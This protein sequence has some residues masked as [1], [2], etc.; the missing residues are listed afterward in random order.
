MGTEDTVVGEFFSAEV[1]SFYI[2][3]LGVA[4]T[5]GWKTETEDWV[6]MGLEMIGHIIFAMVIAIA[7]WCWVGPN[8]VIALAVIFVAGHIIKVY[9]NFKKWWQSININNVA[10]KPELHEY[11]FESLQLNKG[12]N[13]MVD[14]KEKRTKG[15]KFVGYIFM[16]DERDDYDGLREYSTNLG[17][18][19]L[20]V[21]DEYGKD[22]TGEIF[23]DNVGQMLG[24]ILN[25]YKRRVRERV[26]TA[27]Q[28]LKP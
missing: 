6:K 9:Q 25:E 21:F 8:G 26:P 10:T 20:T 7:I 18:G 11:I 17:Q 28:R 27:R 13:E 1:I 15:L 22:T 2:W 4:I 19:T 14:R 12:D 24:A 5:F 23:F 16:P 3:V